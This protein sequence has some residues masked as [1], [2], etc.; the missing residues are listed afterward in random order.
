MVLSTD[1]KMSTESE[2]QFM[3]DFKEK[4]MNYVS[5]SIDKDYECEMVI[6][7][8]IISA[9]GFDR[10]IRYAKRHHTIEKTLHRE[11]L[12]IRTEKSDVRVT[13]SGK[14]NIYEYCKTNSIPLSD[15]IV[16]Q[17]NR[18]NQYQYNAVQKLH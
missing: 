11:T 5:D 8:H 4:F 10:M 7:K 15:V 6:N 18:V 13:I 2:N 17:K 9:E 16:V 14:D 1:S 12:D 3:K